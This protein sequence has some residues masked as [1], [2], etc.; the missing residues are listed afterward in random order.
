METFGPGSRYQIDATPA[1]V[2]LL[3]SINTDKV[4]GRP[5]V[6]AVIDVYSRLVVG[7]YM[8]V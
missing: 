8:W 1:D 6:Y 4:I 5:V 7:I 2:Y 3:S